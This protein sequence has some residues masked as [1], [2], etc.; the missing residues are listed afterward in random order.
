MSR[1]EYHLLLVNRNFHYVRNE[2]LGSS[3]IPSAGPVRTPEPK[4]NQ[5]LSMTHDNAAAWAG[6]GSALSNIWRQKAGSPSMTGVLSI[7]LYLG[8]VAVLHITFPALF[9]LETF[10]SPRR[11]P[12]KHRVSQRTM[13]LIILHNLGVYE[14]TLYDVLDV[15]IGVG[16]ATV[17]AIGFN[18]TCGYLAA[19]EV[20]VT[21]S[22]ELGAWGNIKASRN[23]HSGANIRKRCLAWL[24]YTEAKNTGAGNTLMD[25]RSHR[26]PNSVTLHDLENAL[27][28]LVASMFW[29]LGHIPPTHGSIAWEYRNRTMVSVVVPPSNSTFLL[30]GNATVTEMFTQVHVNSPDTL[31]VVEHNC[32]R[33]GARGIHRPYGPRP[34]VFLVP[35]H[36]DQHNITIDGTGLLHA[37]WLYRNHPEL[38]TLLDQVEHPTDENLREAGMVRV[39][40]VGGGRGKENQPL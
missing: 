34:S 31:D 35:I 30:R 22:A 25:L 27:S 20:N 10:D 26:H 13:T 37:I 7:L 33:S 4:S 17:D 9:S 16:N 19:T 6:I 12:S 21:Y 1:Q 32:G 28:K 14:G 5:M 3:G 29:T 39:R 11:L 40:L 15:N 36:D 18:I 8:N 23:C 38:S 2:L 24:P